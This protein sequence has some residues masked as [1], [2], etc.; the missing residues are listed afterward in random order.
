EPRAARRP[1]ARSDAWALCPGEL[2]RRV[3]AAPERVFAALHRPWRW[4]EG[5]PELGGRLRAELDAFGLELPSL[6]ASRRSHDGSTKLLLRT[7]ADR[8]EAVHMPR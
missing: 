1:P 2:A 5:R 8:I 3:S 6:D 7:G 4:R